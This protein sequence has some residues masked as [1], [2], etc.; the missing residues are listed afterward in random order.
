MRKETDLIFRTLIANVTTLGSEK[1]NRQ[2][3]IEER[4]KKNSKIYLT[5]W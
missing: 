2:S 4:A 3:I 1:A 5:L